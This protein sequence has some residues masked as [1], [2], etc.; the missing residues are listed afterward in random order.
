MA[1]APRRPLTL[2]SDWSPHLGNV[3]IF[4]ALKAAP[5]QRYAFSIQMPAKPDHGDLLS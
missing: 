1:A 5:G 3:V 4:N 2:P